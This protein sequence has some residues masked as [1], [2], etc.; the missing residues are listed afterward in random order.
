MLLEHGSAGLE[1]TE[2]FAQLLAD[3][4]TIRRQVQQ[5]FL[6]DVQAG[7]LLL[8]AA[9]SFL[10]HCLLVLQAVCH[11][12]AQRCDLPGRDA[13]GSDLARQGVLNVLDWQV[14]Q[15]MDDAHIDCHHLDTQTSRDVR[16]IP[17]EHTTDTYPHNPTP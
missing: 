16:P 1:V 15:T 2:P 14:R 17:P 5:P 3:Q 12:L 4:P 9:P 10:L 8:Q 6:L 13:Q 11:L 7:Q